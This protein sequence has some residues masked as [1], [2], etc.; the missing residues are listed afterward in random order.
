LAEE[1]GSLPTLNQTFIEEN[2]PID[3]VVAVNTEPDLLFDSYF[4][5]RCARPMPLFGVPGMM[6]RF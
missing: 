5:L 6:D 2:P 3:R 1:F 4:N